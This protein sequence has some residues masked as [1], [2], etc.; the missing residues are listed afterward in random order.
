MSKEIYA[1]LAEL[2]EECSVQVKIC[3]PSTDYYRGPDEWSED[4][5]TV[6]DTALLVQA[7]QLEAEIAE[8]N[9]DAK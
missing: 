8:I 7:L 5:I 2:I 6:V 1:R 3:V 9:K 4:S